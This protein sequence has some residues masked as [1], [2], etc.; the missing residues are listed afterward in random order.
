MK[1]DLKKRKKFPLQHQDEKPGIEALMHPMPESVRKDYKASNK[2]KGKVAIIT[3]GDSGIGRAVA[4]TYALEGAKV[5]IVYLNE[6][7]D[8][9][10]TEKLIKRRKGKS[11]A[12]AGDIADPE[13]CKQVVKKTIATFGRLDILVNNA[14]EIKIQKHFKDITP[15]QLE[16]TFKTN[17]FGMFYMSQAALPYLKKDGVIINTASS[18]AYQGQKELVDYSASKG[19]VVAFT[20]S[21]SQNLLSKKIRVNAVSPGPVWTPLITAYTAREVANIG[22]E[23]PMER[24]GQPSEIAPCYVFLASDDAS[25]ITGQVLHPNGG[26]VYNT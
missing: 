5:V 7:K 15:Q 25:Y 19:A 4:L 26:V 10:Q 6:H 22:T 20:R 17:I 8:A 23:V 1:S 2:L 13:F 3:G 14:G 9:E 12:I 24:P 11:L 16:R 18:S 21:L